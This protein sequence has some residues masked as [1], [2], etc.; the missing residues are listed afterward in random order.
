M[1]AENILSSKMYL[2]WPLWVSNR[3]HKVE[4]KKVGTGIGEELE[5]RDW[6]RLDQNTLHTCMEFPNNK[7]SHYFYKETRCI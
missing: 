7:K 4:R 3:A 6:G 5:G 2:E 1:E